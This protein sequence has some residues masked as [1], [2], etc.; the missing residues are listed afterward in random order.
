MKKQ[1][2]LREIKM[3]M[4]AVWLLSC[5]GVLYDPVDC[6]LPVSSVPEIS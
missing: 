2:E 6:S 1:E 4:A 5:V 3:I